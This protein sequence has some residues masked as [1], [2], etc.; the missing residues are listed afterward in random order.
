MANCAS[1]NCQ[2]LTTF[3]ST[4]ANCST[5]RGGGS[6]SI[7]LLG[8]GHTITDITDLAQVEAA[9]AGGT[10]WR[11]ENVKVGVSPGSPETIAPVTSCGLERVINN[12]YTAS[13]YAAQ[14]DPDNA[15][16]ISALTS[17]YVIGGIAFGVCPTDSLSNI[18]L[19]ADREV[20]FTGGLVLPDLS[21]DV[22]RFE[23]TASWKGNLTVSV[24]TEG[25]F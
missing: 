3:E 18:I 13:I 6:S 8:C 15:V 7:L 19:Y 22:I 14:V 4:L 2:S 20:S 23:M 11:M 16:F 9:I 24:D 5:Y 17:G 12:T 1:Y 21:S 25:V 10:A